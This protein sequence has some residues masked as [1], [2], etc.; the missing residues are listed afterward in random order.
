[1]IQ[2]LMRKTLIG[3]ML[4][5][6]DGVAFQVGLQKYVITADNKL[7]KFFRITKNFQTKLLEEVGAEQQNAGPPGAGSDTLYTIDYKL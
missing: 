3:I 4:R 7:F 2:K 5:N 6:R 1:M